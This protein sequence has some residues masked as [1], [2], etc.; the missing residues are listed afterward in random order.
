MFFRL[1]ARNEVGGLAARGMHH[2]NHDSVPQTNRLKTLLAVGVTPVF[3]ANRE[4]REN[5]LRTNEIES[6]PGNVAAAFV[7][8]VTDHEQI[9]DAFSLF[10]QARIA[11]RSLLPTCRYSSGEF[12]SQKGNAMS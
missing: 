1:S 7:F 3:T 4:A 2:E 5:F 8:V 10:G 6:V 11:A 9:V 12:F